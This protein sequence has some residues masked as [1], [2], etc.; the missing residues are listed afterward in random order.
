MANPNEADA[1][2]GHATPDTRAE[3][4]GRVYAR[5]L[6]GA[7]GKADAVDA[8]VDQ[9]SEFVR[10]GLKHPSL[11]EALASPR[12]KADEKIR[13]LERLLRGKVHDRLLNFLK[14]VAQRDRLAELPE[15][16]RA[17]VRLRDDLRGRLVVEVQSAEPLTDELRGVI[18]SQLSKR[19]DKAVEL[20]EQVDEKLLGGLIVR[21]GDTVYDSSVEGRLNALS[22]AMKAG[23]AKRLQISSSTLTQS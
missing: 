8:V 2:G 13:V 21:V 4:L 5:A 19:F 15:I 6:L 16:Q 1:N 14:V 9:L 7:A 12:I 22:K 20:R 10:E 11:R 23:F 3:Q 18:K 17:A